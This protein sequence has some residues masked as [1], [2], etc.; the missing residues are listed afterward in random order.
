MKF[1]MPDSFDGLSVD[2]LSTLRSDALA[3]AKELL[4][5]DDISDE[6]LAEVE[7]LNAHVTAIGEA[8][9]A[10]IAAT[11]AREEKIANLKSQIESSDK[12]EE[13]EAPAEDAP[14]EDADKETPEAEA[15]AA[16]ETDTEAP[17]DEVETP[18]DVVVPDDIS[19]LV[20]D[21][22]PEDPT[23]KEEEAMAAARTVSKAARSEA[24]D[25]IAE[26]E[27][28]LVHASITASAAGGKFHSGQEIG[29]MDELTALFSTRIKGLGTGSTK[30]IPTGVL[31]FSSAGSRISIAS[32]NK[33]DNERK[34]KGSAGEQFAAIMEAANERNLSGGSLTAA[35]TN[36]WCAPS[37]ILWDSFLELEAVDALLDLPQM[38]ADRGGI[39]FTKGP[40]MPAI[41]AQPLG[42]QTEAE[43][44]ALEEKV[45]YSVD[46]P[47]W[48]EVRLDAVYFCLTSGILTNAAYPELVRRTIDLTRKGHQLKMNAE[49]IRR[50][51]AAIG[52]ATNHVEVGGSTSDIL[53][54]L[55]IQALRLRYT[56][57]MSA[58]ASIEVVLPLWARDLVRADLS[59][60][61]GV[62]N[63]LSISDAQID[64][65]F[66]E[67]KLRVQFV[68][69]YQDLDT[70]LTGAWTAFPN[71]IEAMLYP[72]GSYVALTKD[73]IELDAIHDSVN[74][75]TNRYTAVFFEEGLAVANTGADGVKV[76]ISVNV[77][78]LTGFPAVGAGAG[79]TIPTP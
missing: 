56:L 4:S 45:C 23:K 43:A 30:G 50:I 40:Q 22:N 7:Q 13:E 26:V 58:D 12:A 1:K 18:E 36:S 16:P 14:A 21:E 33:P 72:A 6:Q 60:R 8:R 47:D 25:E 78:G 42:I 68:R 79:V 27:P 54:A 53:D 2:E 19:E 75:S 46:C 34:L 17:V 29:T 73:V 62:E 39:Q 66:R 71:V 9:D 11:A 44:D 5:A 59:R 48:E 41:L 51:S 76:S 63:F 65:M 20:E 38:V 69:G 15:E 57:S 37:E 74:T 52:A 32:I 28:E 77:Q 24:L 67:R 49:I 3:E 35:A 64:A 10:S 61:T 55:T 70:T 31:P